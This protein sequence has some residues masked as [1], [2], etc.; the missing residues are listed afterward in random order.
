MNLLTSKKLLAVLISSALLSA[1]GSS[2]SDDKT[3]D[4]PAPELP[5]YST[6]VLDATDGSQAAKLDFVSASAVTD[7][8]WQIAYQKYLGFKLNGG[9]SASGKVSGCVAHEYSNLFDKEGNPVVDKF[10]ALTD[11]STLTDFD[12]VDASSCTEFKFDTL[13]T[14]IKTENWLDADYSQG[15]PVYSAKAGNG[16][17]IRSA[18]GKEYSRVKVKTVEV[19]FGATTT[20]KV[21][22]STELWNGSVFAAA[23]DSPVLDFSSKRVF[24]DLETNTLV[25][26][27]ADWDLS[28]TVNGRDYPLQIN[29]GA[30]GEGKGGSGAVM[31]KL[32][33]VTD[34]VD[35][36]QVY[37]YFADSASGVLSAPGN[38]GP[39]QYAV[40][41]GH[42]MWPTFTTYLIKDEAASGTRLFK[43]QLLSNYGEN[44]ELAS[45]NLV[46]RY[47]EITE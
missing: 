38:Y 23:V 19:A 28:L 24:W 33:D 30:S 47:Q 36:T 4:P 2:S 27:N 42:K 22:L 7:D 31:V 12:K 9:V 25:A 10:K 15:A 32:D 35:T 5:K 3:P 29:G 16:W 43:M 41:G 37:K 46:F 26:E 45:A 17:I 40:D 6:V 39:L 20:R 11:A 18:D 1:C 8:T 34:P 21:T 13:K 14:A 44:G